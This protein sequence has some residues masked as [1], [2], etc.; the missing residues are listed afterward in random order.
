MAVNSGDSITAAQFNGLQSRINQVLGTGSGTFGYGQSVSSSQVTSLTDPDIPDGDSVTAQQFNQLRSDLR[1]AFI[2]QTGTEIPVNSFS[3][4][5]IIGAD[6]SG[7]DI[8]FVNGDAVFVNEDASKGFNDLLSI[9]SGLEAGRFDIHP[10]Q[11]D[12]QVRAA[13]ERTSDWNGTIVSAFTVSFSNTDERRFFFNSGGEIRISGTND[14]NTS[15]GDSFERDQGW[16][17]L[18]ENP[19]EIRFDYNSTTI[20]GST[21]GVSFPDGAIGNEDLTGSYQTIF[22]K[23]ASGG[24]YSDSYWKIDA[25]EDSST[26]LRFRIELVD[27]G[28]E[29]DDDA[30]EPGS[31]DG[32]IVEPITADLEFE[33]AAR[34]ANGEVVVPFPAFSVVNTFE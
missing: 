29:S 22:R 5:D 18:L 15:T 2:H 13:D 16:D 26:Q 9:M 34:R 1:K 33:Y 20:T 6:E 17:N 27:A 30:G 11:Q 21:S 32:G 12:V 3:V 24:V 4:G 7:T 28:P 31:I 8:D 25:R 10:S 23:D 19:G 14:L